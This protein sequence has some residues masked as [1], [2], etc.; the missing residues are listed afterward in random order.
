MP[1]YSLTYNHTLAILKPIKSKFL[2]FDDL[3][4]PSELWYKIVKKVVPQLLIDQFVTYE[5]RFTVI[6]EGW[7]DIAY[8]IEEN[9]KY[10]TLP[11]G[12]ENP[13]NIIPAEIQHK[14][15]IQS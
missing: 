2:S 5:P 14:L 7:P 12:V 9:G 15:W 11:E 13:I 6:T 3:P 1:R 4:R 10:L 8:E